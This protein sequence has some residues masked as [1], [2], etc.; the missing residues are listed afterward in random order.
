[1]FIRFMVVS[2]FFSTGQLNP[3]FKGVGVDQRRFMHWM[4]D[5]DVQT[6]RSFDGVISTAL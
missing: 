6:S 2:L 1:M 4:T 5:F 3:N